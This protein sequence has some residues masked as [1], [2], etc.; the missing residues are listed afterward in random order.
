MSSLTRVAPQ[1]SSIPWRMCGTPAPGSPPAITVRTARSVAATPSSSSQRCA[2]WVTKDAVP[3]R[4]F[5]CRRCIDSAMRDVV[6]PP[7][8][9]SVPPV[10]RMPSAYGK[11]AGDYRHT[12]GVGDPGPGGDSR[13]A[14]GVGDTGR[15]A[16]QVVLGQA[17]E[18]GG[19]G[20]A[21]RT[22]D[23]HELVGVDELEPPERPVGGRLGLSGAQ[24]LLVRDRHVVS[25][26]SERIV[27]GALRRR[28]RQTSWVRRRP[29]M[30]GEASS[31]RFCSSSH[32]MVS[33]S[34]LNSCSAGATRGVV[35]GRDL[36]ERRGAVS[37]SAR[38][39]CR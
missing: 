2:K 11:P 31:W 19:S 37:L 24:I 1:A 25:A 39:P 27:A 14:V 33:T 13:G 22:G 16:P 4:T 23:L 30:L 38:A 7:I 29:S 8:Q 32:D 20:G 28:S 15:P 6:W 12:R 10:P 3:T 18:H 5:S 36:L 34:A 35:I 17:E 21:R 26:S 9:A